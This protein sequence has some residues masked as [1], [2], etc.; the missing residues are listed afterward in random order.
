MDKLIKITHYSNAHY[1]MQP[2]NL[3]DKAN[4]Y[5]Y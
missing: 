2:P 1:V 5:F 3:E 4:H